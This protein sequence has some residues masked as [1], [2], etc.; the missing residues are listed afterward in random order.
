MPPLE[1]DLEKLQERLTHDRKV[2]AL[3]AAGSYGTDQAWRG[4][5]PTLLSFER[6]LVSAQSELRAGILHLRQ[7]F[8][9]L[10]Q[11]RDWDSAQAGAPLAT[12]ATARTL[13]DPTG[14]LGRIQ[15]MLL[16][17][18]GTQRALYREELLSRAQT[19][20]DAA[21][22]ALGRGQSVP[23][24]LLALVAARSLALETLYPALLGWLH[25]WPE[26][27]LRLPHA[28]RATAG[29]RF[30]RSVYGLERLYAF[31]G[32]DEARR[33]LL[34]TR[35]LGMLE[36]ERRARLAHQAG[37]YDGAVRLL[38][39]EAAALHRADLARWT[40]LSAARQGKLST[41]IGLERSPLGPTALK[42]AQ[43]LLED[44]REG[45]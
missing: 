31:G 20:L 32:E 35:G 24:Q 23:E 36:Q 40:A 28:W 18:T 38:R 8:E 9:R 44:V 33:C 37:Y 30:P 27:E 17:L 34:A 6:G 11:W 22:A 45:R 1:A 7:P 26:F 3:A 12:L 13:Y 29:L 14:N 2:R 43:E 39:D 10:E 4:S 19:R 42:I 21:R 41:L 25:A 15:K 5:V 16:G